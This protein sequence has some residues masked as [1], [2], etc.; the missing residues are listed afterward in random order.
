MAKTKISKVER[1]K[2]YVDLY[3]FYRKDAKSVPIGR[4]LYSKICSDFNKM[5]MELVHEGHEIVLPERAGVLRIF[6]SKSA[7]MPVHWPRTKALWEKSE[8][9]KK[10][11]KLVYITN[12]HSDGYCYV[13]RWEKTRIMAKFKGLFS[14]ETTKH[15]RLALAKNIFAGKE[16]ILKTNRIDY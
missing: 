4:V 7:K 8:K 11:K 5:L 10:E 2:N 15:N 14:M 16:Y 13:H 3:Q 12:D 9:A 6:G 1:D